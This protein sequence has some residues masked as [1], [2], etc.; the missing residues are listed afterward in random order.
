M[1]GPLDGCDGSEMRRE[2]QRLTPKAKVSVSLCNAHANVRV[3]LAPLPLFLLDVWMLVIV[4]SSSFGLFLPLWSSGNCNLSSFKPLTI[5]ATSTCL[6]IVLDY[7]LY[8]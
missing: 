3:H 2:T 1:G 5:P 6:I 7:R 4:S 8:P